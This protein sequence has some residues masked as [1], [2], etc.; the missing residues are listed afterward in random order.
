[1]IQKY[2]TS[3]GKTKSKFQQLKKILSHE[4]NMVERKCHLPNLSSQ[5]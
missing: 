5:F 2:F 3:F 4:K 1:M